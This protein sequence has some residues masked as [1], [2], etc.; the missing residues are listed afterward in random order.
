MYFAQNSS[1]R[2]LETIIL[3]ID[4]INK[5]G[6]K[7]Y[8][9]FVQDLISDAQCIAQGKDFSLLKS[10]SIDVASF[11]AM[12]HPDFFKSVDAD[13]VS[14]EKMMEFQNL[15]RSDVSEAIL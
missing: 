1:F 11:V 5:S 8:K 2:S 13:D 3:F 10:R 7:E 14:I 12:K 6:K 4:E 9:E 15:L